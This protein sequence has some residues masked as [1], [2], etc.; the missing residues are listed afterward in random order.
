MKQVFKIILVPCLAAF[1]LVSCARPHDEVVV[2]PKTSSYHTG[3]CAR[4][5][6]ARAVVETRSQAIREGNKPCPL[7]NP[8]GKQQP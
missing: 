5:Q 6:M 3:D 4:V 8:D 2:I 1:V 7:C